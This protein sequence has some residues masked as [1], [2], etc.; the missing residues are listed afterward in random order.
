MR[1]LVVEDNQ[2]LAYGISTSLEFQGYEVVVAPDGAEGLQQAREKEF[3]LLILDLMLP[4]LDGFRVLRKLRDEGND[5]PVLILTARGQEAD[6]V[7][8]FELGADDYVTKPFSKVELL[9]RVKARLRRRERGPEGVGPV[10][11][12]GD[13]DVNLATRTVVCAGEAVSVAPREFDLLLA[14]I[15]RRGAV[16]TRLELLQEV[17]GHRA[18]VE[19]RTVDY[20]VAELRRKLE[21]DPSKPRHI[22]TVYKVGYRLEP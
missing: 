7:L 18:A 9:A 20:H 5:V 3:D 19:T 14:L 21:H 4:E 6:K 15:R 17:W 12:F 11:R 1:I 16:A 13:V 8:G 2:N 22:L 10:E